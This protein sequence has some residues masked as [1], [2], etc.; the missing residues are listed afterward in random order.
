MLRSYE[1]V[2]PGPFALVCEWPFL[3]AAACRTAWRGRAGKSII[4]EIR[5]RVRSRPLPH[6]AVSRVSF[7]PDSIPCRFHPFGG[8][9]RDRTLCL[10]W[11]ADIPAPSST[12][13]IH[14]PDRSDGSFRRASAC[15]MTTRLPVLLW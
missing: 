2:S 14:R 8:E 1:S 11:R 9:V 15:G 5:G 7:S 4:R 3:A 10:Q 12:T 6:F 13:S